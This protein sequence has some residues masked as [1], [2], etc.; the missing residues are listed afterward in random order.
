MELG[1]AAALVIMVHATAHL[2]MPALHEDNRKEPMIEG[3]I[4]LE[5]RA[6]RRVGRVSDNFVRTAWGPD[7]EASAF[8]RL[9]QLHPFKMPSCIASHPHRS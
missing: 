3:R 5:C 8:E 4:F 6:T 2:A 7:T 9:G 1:P